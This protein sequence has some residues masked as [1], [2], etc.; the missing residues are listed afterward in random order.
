M[1]T[2]S[3]LLASGYANGYEKK[4]YTNP[5]IYH[6]GKNYDLTKRWYV[7][8]SFLNPITLKLVRQN[9]IT[10]G[11]NRRFKTKD[12]R[13]KELMILRDAVEL[14]LKQGVYNPYD[15]PKDNANTFQ[16]AFKYAL[17]IKR[18]EVKLTTFKDYES[19]LKLF[20]DYLIKHGYRSTIITKIDKKLVSDFLNTIKGPKNRN[21][22][23]ASLSA[24]FSVL[25]DGDYIPTNFIKD[26]RNKKVEPKP[27]KIY[28]ADEIANIT[29]LLKK[30]DPIL[31]MFIQMVSYMFIRPIELTRIKRKDI[32]DHV[33]KFQSKTGFKTKMIPDIIADDL[34]EFIKDKKGY[35]FD[36]SSVSE[37]DKRDYYTKRFLKFKKKHGIDIDLKLYSFRHTFIT[38]VYLELRKQYSKEETIKKL[39]LITGHTSKAI[40]NY[41]Q[42]NDIELPDDYSKML[43]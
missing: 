12:D 26:I 20:N 5:K 33:I 19:R 36:D 31:L 24:I 14:L 38:K 17:N 41:I 32:T 22:T 39:S 42:V 3:K 27:I 11:V 16:D 15:T 29:E 28:S 8:F 37:K 21:N 30:D 1:K 10:G 7:Y 4:K 25:A 2:L 35:I 40:Y 43:L 9:R 18:K 34:A 23:R 6:G 13:L